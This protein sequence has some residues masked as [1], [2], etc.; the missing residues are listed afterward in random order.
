MRNDLSEGSPFYG[1]VINPNGTATLEWRLF[2]GIQQRQTVSLGTISFPAWFQVNRYTDT[3]QSPH[4]TYYSL[5]TSSDGNTWTEVNGSTV[6]LNLG[7]NPLAGF[8][9]SSAAPKASNKSVWDNVAVSN[10]STKPSGV[11]PQTYT[12]QDIATGYISGSQEF[13]NGT[14]R[15]AAGGSDIWDVYDQFHYVYQTLTAD[16]TVSAQVTSAGPASY[17]AEWEKAGVMLRQTSDPQSP[18]YGV[19]VTP[20]HGIAVQWRSAQAAQTSQVLFASAPSYPVYVMAT[21]WTDPHAGGLTYFTAYYSTDNK[22]FTVIPNSTVA[23]PMTGS[24]LAGMAADSYNEKTTYPVVFNNFALFNNTE[25]PPPG[26]CPAAVAGCADFGGATPPGSQTLSGSTLTVSTGGGDIWGTSDQ[27]HYVWQTLAGDGVVSADVAQQQNTGAWAKAGVML[28]AAPATGPPTDPGAPYYA[29]FVTPSNGV[30]V[31]WRSAEN[32]STAQL[33]VA[34]AAPLYL[35]VVRF[36]DSSGNQNF[37]AY[38]SSDGSTWT[39]ITGSTQ[40]LALTGTLLAGWAADA[41][42]QTTAGQVV[43][44]NTAVTA[45]SSIPPGACPTS[46]TCGDLGSPTPAGSQ[47]L[48]GSSWNVYGGGG[49]I[50]STSDQFHYVYQSLA[51][52]GTVSADVTSQQNSNPWAK[53]GVMLRST[54]DPASPYYAAFVTPANGIDVQ[55]RATSGAATN[56]VLIP[57][58]APQYLEVQRWTDTS[59]ST[60]VTYYYALTS[61]DGSTWTMVSGSLQTLNLGAPLLAGL[62]VT[63]HNTTALSNVA[64]SAVS[65]SSTSTEPPGVCLQSFSC[66]DI[67]G[68][69]PAGSQST[70]NGAWTVQAGGGDIWGTSDQ[71]R[72]AATTIPGDGVSS[73]R[74]ASLQNTN[75]WAKAGL[76]LRLSTDPAAPYYALLVT[77]GNGLVVQYRTTQ[78]GSTNQIVVNSLTAPEYLQITRSGTT[79]TAAYSSDGSTWTTVGGSATVVAALTGT[80][81]DGMATTSHS[82]TALT[83]AVYDTLNLP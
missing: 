63:S 64:M 81:L 8:G 36:T 7:A 1:V 33:L 60:P 83:G 80:L 40:Q 45:G 44:S 35:K 50:W 3:T 48:S 4:V 74:V 38:T 41:Y 30:D 59:G 51:G 43:F 62:A 19:F 78:G 77:P 71:F 15:F 73:L 6:A 16:G 49:D 9:G 31:Q 18:Y 37:A 69:T 79:F 56:Q 17:D 46:W 14:W 39:W 42:S 65:I 32:G 58:A 13:A 29:V 26:S 22:N 68:A 75:S 25:D 28:R 11:C 57:G 34:G 23:L 55:W 21:R 61:T 66:S 76:M 27:F 2:N 24:L 53:A 10:V 54:T 82:Q 5:M 70:S 52:D 67:G 72:Y 20:Q 47:T 12:C